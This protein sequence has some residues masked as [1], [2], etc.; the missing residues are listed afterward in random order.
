MIT[1]KEIDLKEKEIL[2]KL[3]QLYLHDISL[4]F[5]IEYDEKTILYKYDDIN[6]YFNN[7]E[8]KAFFIQNDKN[9]VGFILI[10]ITKEKNIVQEIF[11]LNNHKRKGIGKI[12]VNKIF[13]KYKGIWEVKSLPNK[14]SAE[15]FWI[16]TI[17][18][19]TKD[20]FKL[21]YVGKYNRAVI[22]FNNKS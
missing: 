13:E 12:A 17:K 19:Y 22:T 21:E 16:S 20:N 9:I 10:N 4:Y 2:D 18:E 3:M 14:K 8:N 1:L 11:I 5:P 6:K 15:E 7:E